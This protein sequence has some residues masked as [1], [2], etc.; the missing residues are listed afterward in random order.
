MD[1]VIASI[2]LLIIIPVLIIVML[3]M[4]LSQ[5]FP[6]FF[7]QSRVGKDF[8]Y[9]RIHK[10]RT[11]KMHTED[12]SGLTK[13]LHDERITKTGYFL[14][15]YKI[16]E[17]PQLIN[18]LKG[19]MSI[20]GSRPQVPFY[21]TKFKVFYSDILKRKPGLLSPAAIL[22]SNEEELLDSVQDPF[23][24]YEQI[25]IPVKCKMD[26]QLVS[27]FSVKVYFKVI[28]DYFKKNILQP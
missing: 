13:G 4:I 17:L 16:D 24:Y 19:E 14:R 27:E 26:I 20:V 7:S 11:M 2:M 1:V 6:L 28:F 10:L 25:L 18:I 5:G 12:E 8:I 22:Y 15:K 9:F 3:I 21:T 23:A